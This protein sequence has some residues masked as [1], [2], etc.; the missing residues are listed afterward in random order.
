[1]NKRHRTQP[2]ADT[3][4]QDA[5][6][7]DDATASTDSPDPA[8]TEPSDHGSARDDAADPNAEPSPVEPQL[9]DASEAPAAQTRRGRR[10]RKRDKAAAASSAD[11]PD[12]SQPGQEDQASGPAAS[13]SEPPATG[14]STGDDDGSPPTDGET[15]PPPRKGG[16]LLTVVALLLALAAGGAAG[17]LGWRLMELEAR[18]E[19]IPQERAAALDPLPTQDAVDDAVRQT[20][21]RVDTLEQRIDDRERALDRRLSRAEGERSEAISRLRQRVDTAETAVQSLRDR[22][23]RDGADWRMA[24]VRFLVS[25]AVRQL[26]ITGNIS[27][28]I[29]A[30]EAADHALGQMG[31]PRVLDLRERIV[32][33]ISRLREVEPADVEGIALRVQNLAP[34]IPALVQAQPDDPPDAETPTPAPD[35]SA[36]GAD[37]G[38]WASLRAGL[39]GLVS[40]RREPEP[41]PPGRP[42][43]AA[44]PAPSAELP[45]AERLL[46]ALREASRAALNHEPEAYRAAIDRALEVIAAEYDDAAPANERFRADLDALRE[47]RIV[48]ELPDLEPTL[49]R[50]QSLATRLE[51]GSGDTQGDR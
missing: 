8:S 27:A 15:P 51:D 14:G 39:D 37:G 7:A 28:G 5:P 45:P 48:T 3:S 12:A 16:R 49:E 22:R 43:P 38:W 26:Q 17:Y 36:A 32:A 18:V 30:L 4:A 9:P 34:Q 6:S 35:H 44:P 25:M 42:G 31:D 23:E 29:A 41:A 1:M 40:V 2:P 50:T 21:Q 10:A 20:T 33:D 47:R 46:L 11:A 24:E 19:R 13:E